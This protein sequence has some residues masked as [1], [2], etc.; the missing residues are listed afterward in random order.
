[1]AIEQ[2]RIEAEQLA[3]SEEEKRLILRN[4]LFSSFLHDLKQ[5]DFSL[6]DFVDHA[7]DPATPLDYDWHWRGFFA[8]KPLVERIFGYW[9]TS[10][11][12]KT[13]RVFIHNWATEQVTKR[14]YSEA[15]EIT[16][17]GILSKAKKVVNEHFFLHF[18]LEGL[19]TILRSMAPTAFAVFEAFS[20]TTRQLSKSSVRGLQKKAMVRPIAILPQLRDSFL[21]GAGCCRIESAPHVQSAQ[22]LFSGRNSHLPRRNWRAM[23]ALLRSRIFW[24]CSRVFNCDSVSV[25]CIKN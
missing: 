5:N 18:S 25:T 16:K 17:T 4:Q 15:R 11:Y 7:F 10:K 6:A 22:Q 13:T 19:T 14:V 9:T 12:N 24:S 20:T 21:T 3:R 1:M 8:Q 2:D 23:S